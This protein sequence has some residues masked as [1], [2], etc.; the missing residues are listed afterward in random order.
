MRALPFVA[1]L[2]LI[3][4]APTAEAGSSSVEIDGP[5]RLDASTP[6]SS[7]IGVALLLDGVMCAGQAEIPL[8]LSIS[9]QK[10]VH[11][12]SLSS[13]TILFRVTGTESATKPWRADSQVALRVWGAS[14]TGTVSVTASY[15]LPPNCHV[16]GGQTKGEATHTIAIDGPQP[17]P[18]REPLPQQP[19]VAPKSESLLAPAPA[20]ASVAMPRPPMPVVGAILGMIAGGA[21]VFWQRMR[22]FA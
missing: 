20:H 2:L 15:A 6:T 12:A 18:V 10:G 11:S 19:P 13:E 1:A 7:E 17:P 21:V 16:V 9:D 4:T 22:A 14:P 8:R 5:G 3:W